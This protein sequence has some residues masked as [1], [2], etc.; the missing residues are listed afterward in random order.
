MGGGNG[1]KSHMSRAKNQEKAAAKKDGGGGGKGIAERT[2]HKNG[3]VCAV[4]KAPFASAKQKVSLTE[5]HE[6]KH[7]KLPFAQCF[8]DL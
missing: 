8:P 7:S 5:H 1:L 6:S 4:C 3:I 2:G